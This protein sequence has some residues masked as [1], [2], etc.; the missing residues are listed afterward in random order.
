MSRNVTTH[1]GTLEIIRRLP[2]STNGNPRWLL[3]VDGW[4]CRTPVDSSLGYSV[5]NYQ[6]KRVRA[7]IGTHYG[8]ATLLDVQTA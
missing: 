5:T 8:V 7:S 6:G 3:R 4:E 2:S 1:T